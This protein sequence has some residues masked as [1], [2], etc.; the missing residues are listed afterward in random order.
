M[1]KGCGTVTINGSTPAKGWEGWGSRG[2]EGGADT[3]EL[4]QGDVHR[5]LTKESKSILCTFTKDAPI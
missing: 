3:V 1:L 2:E 4:L 5:P